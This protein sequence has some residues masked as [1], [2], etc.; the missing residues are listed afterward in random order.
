MK[1]LKRVLPIVLLILVGLIVVGGVGGYWFITKSHPQINGTLQVKGLKSKV[2][3]VRDPMGIPHIY[4]DNADDL[5]FAQGY[6]MAQDRLW[7]MEY[8]RRIGHG[9]LSDIFGATTIKTDRFLRTLGL[10]RAAHAD[11][12]AMSA[13]DKRPLQAFAN[14][15]NAFIDSHLDN[16]PLE[17]TI[18]GFKP[19]HWEPVDTVA[20]GKVMA[21]NLGGNYEAEL[22]RA[23]MIEKIGVEKM[24]QLLPP[25]PE[26]GPFTIP[27]EAKEYKSH[28]P[29]PQIPI[30]T[31]SIGT[32]NLQEI[33]AINASLG[34]RGD[35]IGSNNWVIDGTK[36]TTGKPILV[37]DPHLGIQLPSIWYEIGLHCTPKTDACPYN[38]EGFTFP[39]VPGVVLGHNDRIAW[40]VTN[41]G[42]DVQDL[43]VEEINPQNPNQYKFNGKWEEMQI[44]EEPI[45]V[46]GVVSETLKVQ[47]TRHG[48]IMTPVLG[49]GVTQPLALQWTA[50]RERSRLFESVL[51]LNRAK[52]WDE[53]RAAL[54]L[55]DVPSQNFVYADVDGNIG[56]QAPGNI[57]IRAKGDGTVPVPGTGEYEW[58]GYIPFDELPF[59]FNPPTHFVA[60]A[61]QAVV[62]TTYKYLLGTDWAAPYREQRIVDL[63][64]AKD[65]LSIADMQAIQGDVYSIPLAQLQPAIAA[66]KPAGF[67]QTRAMDYV[68]SWDGKLT[69]D[70]VGGTILEATYKRLFENIFADKLDKD[71]LATYRG[72]NDYHRRVIIGLLDDPKSAWWGSAGRDAIL[73]KSFAEGVDWLGSQFGDAPGEWKWGR[74]HIATFAHPLGSVQPLNLLFTVG[75]VAAPG[76]VNTVF[77]TS[78]KVVNNRYE[79]SSVTSM[80]AIYDL[81]NLNNSLHIHTTG[82][83]GQPWHKHFSDMV[84]LWRDVKYAPMYFDRAALEKVKEGTL[85]LIPASDH[86]G[87]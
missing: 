79:V 78:F 16:L 40:G 60:T 39:G 36:S 2:E 65:K 54:R 9:T 83:S 62:P 15:V 33:A 4:A 87:D 8:N 56:Y 34:L 49:S 14:G 80:R 72:A 67:L 22:A 6:V 63:L 18:L 58:T 5:F 59:V 11:I 38:V 73:Q 19:A 28:I 68:K 66:L 69:T 32:P 37:N 31:I 57:P 27:P 70:S 77:A 50:L 24:K 64:Q 43:Y 29:N 48:P 55:W 3:I 12:A 85:T 75:P 84:L 71:L 41:L 53:F 1:L 42:P 35:G 17:F 61:N 81:S 30:A 7:Q 10:S 52:N 86:L 45:K 26:T 25:Y 47:I 13:S 20:W 82:Q 74:L 46:K 51:M 76:G 44:V 23:A 21:Y